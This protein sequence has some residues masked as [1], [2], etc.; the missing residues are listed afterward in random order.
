[1]GSTRQKRAISDFFYCCNVVY[2]YDYAT[3]GSIHHLMREAILLIGDVGKA[4]G[5]LE[6]FFN[7]FI[8]AK[9]GYRFLIVACKGERIDLLKVILNSEPIVECA[10]NFNAN[11]TKETYFTGLT[12]NEV[13]QRMLKDARIYEEFAGSS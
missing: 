2:G 9:T 13:V 3:P 5:L 6:H 11:I 7:N 10:Q 8:D 1:M 12:E 4:A